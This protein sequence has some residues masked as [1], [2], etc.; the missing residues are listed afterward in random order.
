MYG[1]WRVPAMALDTLPGTTVAAASAARL[2]LL[3]VYVSTVA[4]MAYTMRLRTP[5][6]ASVTRRSNVVAAAIGNNGNFSMLISLFAPG[7]AGHSRPSRRRSMSHRRAY[8]RPP[9]SRRRT[10]GRPL[11]HDTHV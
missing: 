10:H 4:I 3:G 2:H 9:R 5:Q 7:P 11:T 1:L 6:Q 8:P